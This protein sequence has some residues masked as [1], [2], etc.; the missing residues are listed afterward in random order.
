MSAGLARLRT[1]VTDFTLLVEQAPDE[2]RVVAEGKA[3][4]AALV[5][6]DDW[7][8]DAFAQPD[9]VRYRQYLLHCDPLERFSV[10]SFVW[11][12][13]QQTPVHDHRVWGLIGILRGA[14]LDHHFSRAP[15]GKFVAG[16]AAR[17]E[18]GQVAAVSPSLG[19][20]HQVSNALADRPS[21]SIHVYG[22]NIGAQPRATYDTAT[23]AER[24][25]IS[26]Y[27]NDTVPN[28]WDRSGNP[29]RTKET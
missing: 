8:P 16:E 11:G 24:A 28:L 1:F 9:P 17:L 29:A 23:G 25:F 2:A 5:R 10:V 12:P 26:G 15:D 22:T 4:L 27:S 21:V 20:V 13:G 7:L 6:H 18:P 14:E 3:L 19:D